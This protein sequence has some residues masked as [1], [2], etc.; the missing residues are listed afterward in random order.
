MV[1]TSH[2]SAWTAST[3]HDFTLSPLRWTVQLPQLVV[4]HPTS[5]PMLARIADTAPEVF[6]ARRHLYR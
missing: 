6:A 2:P 5:V 4:S 3:V 1:V